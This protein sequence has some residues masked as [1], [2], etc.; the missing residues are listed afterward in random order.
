MIYIVYETLLFVPNIRQ[1]A[2]LDIL[3]SNKIPREYAPRPPAPLEFDLHIN[4]IQ[5]LPLSTVYI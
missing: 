4:T 1:N 2:P 5:E 3:G